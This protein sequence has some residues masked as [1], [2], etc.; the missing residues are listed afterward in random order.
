M[1]KKSPLENYMTRKSDHHQRIETMSYYQIIKSY[2]WSPRNKIWSVRQQDTIV[3]LYP[4]RWQDS[5][6]PDPSLPHNGQYSSTFATAAH[7]ALLLYVPFMDLSALSDITLLTNPDPDR[8][9]IWYDPTAPIADSNVRWQHCFLWH[10]HHNPNFFPRE[11]INIFHNITVADFNILNDLEDLEGTEW[12]PTPEIPR[13]QPQEWERAAQIPQR[14]NQGEMGEL[15]HYLGTR[16][17][18]QQH[19]WNSDLQSYDLVPNL[20]TF[21]ASH[22]CMDPP[23]VGHRPV[24]DH[25]RL[26]TGQREIYND[27]VGGF[28]D[29]EDEPRNTIVMA[30]AGVGKSF[31]IRALE[32]GLWKSA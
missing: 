2:V 6:K 11:I 23:E 24:V 28:V 7:R 29:R 15:W 18:D 27:I 22:K 25:D 19:D 20:E 8:R 12:D 17:N 3:Q 9:P 13:R 30:T 1:T 14:G 26:N 32:H 10:I 16:D 4:R 5:L 31:L 21:I